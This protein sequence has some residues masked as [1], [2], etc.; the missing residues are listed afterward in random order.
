MII[1]DTVLPLLV[2]ASISRVYKWSVPSGHVKGTV[3]GG[4]EEA[5]AA[6]SGLVR[7]C[8]F[9]EGDGEQRGQ[10]HAGFPGGFRI[11]EGEARGHETLP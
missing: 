11:P 1:E 4:H 2:L 7:R 5:S 10:F 6:I 9:P 3:A 8:F